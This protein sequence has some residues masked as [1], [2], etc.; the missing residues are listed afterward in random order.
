MLARAHDCDFLPHIVN[1]I[2][3]KLLQ[4]YYLD[5]HMLPTIGP[6]KNVCFP[7]EA[8]GPHANGY[9]ELVSRGLG[10][11]GRAAGRLLFL[12]IYHYAMLI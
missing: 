4:V 12:A 11:P 5:C 7:H 8:K 1:A 9:S 3:F 10:D 2:V 6:F